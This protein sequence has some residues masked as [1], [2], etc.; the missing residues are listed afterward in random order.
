MPKDDIDVGI[1]LKSCYEDLKKFYIRYNKH[2]ECH[3]AYARKPRP[4]KLQ[5]TV[6]LHYRPQPST[7]R[8]PT[9]ETKTS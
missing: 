1:M 2:M 8:S 4:K 9:T 7:G 5:I 6:D 3:I